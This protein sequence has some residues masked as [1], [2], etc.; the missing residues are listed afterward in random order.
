MLLSCRAWHIQLIGSIMG[1]VKSWITDHKIGRDVVKASQDTCIVDWMFIKFFVLLYLLCLILKPALRISRIDNG[2]DMRK[3]LKVFLLYCLVST[4]FVTSL[5]SNSLNVLRL[6]I[7]LISHD[8]IQISVT[9]VSFH[10][11]L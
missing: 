6:I 7:N 5:I 10:L 3:F 1:L 8:W 9:M 11:E 4:L 2:F